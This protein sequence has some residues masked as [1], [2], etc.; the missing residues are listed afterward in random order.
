MNVR[1]IAYEADADAISRRI[2][3]GGSVQDRHP[4]EPDADT[5]DEFGDSQ[6]EPLIMII[7]GALAAGW[8]LEQVSNVLLDWRRPGGLLIDARGDEL[9]VRPAPRAERGSIVIVTTSGQ[10][11]YPP[12]RRDEGL[13]TFSNI[14]TLLGGLIQNS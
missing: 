9:I 6:F 7:G 1:W 13:K 10:Q 3:E 8:L 4:W 11:M 5:A 14:L 12:E 2:G